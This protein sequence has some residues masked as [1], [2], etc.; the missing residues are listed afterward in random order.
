MNPDRKE[1]LPREVFEELMEEGAQA[2]AKVLEKLLN[3]AMQMERSEFLGAEPYQRTSRRRDHANGFKDKTVTTRVGKLKLKIPQV[4]H[5]SFY[6]QS[7]QRGCRSEKALKLALAEMYVKGVSTRKVSRITEQLCGTQISATQVS[8]MAQLLDRELEQFR[9]RE[10]GPYP[11]VYLDAHYQKVRVQG[12][13]QDLAILKAIGVNR[14]GKRE[15]LSGLG[16]PE[17]SGGPLEG[18]LTGAATTGA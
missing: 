2:F 8:R 17:R 15:V 12:T 16:G 3:L 13:V 9:Q 4:R 7:L 5:L 11:V 14:W 1:S 6:P 18:V 10:L